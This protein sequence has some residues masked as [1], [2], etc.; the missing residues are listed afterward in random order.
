M[1]AVRAAALGLVLAFSATAMVGLQ[2]ASAADSLPAAPAPGALTSAGTGTA[3]QTVTLPVPADGQ[4]ALLDPDGNLTGAL[5]VAG[6]GTYQISDGT[7]V[8][9]FRPA[10]GY[11]GAHGVLF[12]ETDAYQQVGDG[13]YTPQVAL[14]D[15]PVGGALSSSGTGTD[16]QGVTVAV[17][18]QGTVVLVDASGQVTTTSVIAGTGTFQVDP[19]SGALTFVPDPGYTGSPSIGLRTTDAYGQSTQSTYTATVLAPAAPVAAALSSRAAAQVQ[20]SVRVAV[21]DGA[22]LALLDAAGSPATHVFL[23]GQGNYALDVATS[24]IVFTP[25]QGFSG[26]GSVEY[27]LTDG[28]GQSA[29]NA[30]TPMVLRP[31]DLALAATPTIVKPKKATRVRPAVVLV[32]PVELAAPKAAIMV[33]VAAVD[34]AGVNHAAVAEAALNHAAVAPVAVHHVVKTA[35]R[36]RVLRRATP[37]GHTAKW[38]TSKPWPATR[39]VTVVAPLAAT[40]VLASPITDVSHSNGRLA[41]LALIVINVFV[42]ITALVLNLRRRSN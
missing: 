2:S 41:G 38:V 19:T 30:Y 5:S 31:R 27:R 39:A 3:P 14:P 13:T 8:L 4:V 32:P 16:T 25:A 18:A 20:Q 36:A 15:P 1:G 28:Y 22:D 26:T 34:H 23:A 29:Q 24:T 6:V 11:V 17:P 35:V 21:P 40:A 33:P 7:G 42:G 9:T 37:A 10:V 12:R